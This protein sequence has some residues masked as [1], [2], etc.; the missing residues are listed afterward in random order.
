M[1]NNRNSGFLLMRLDCT[2]CLNTCF[3]AA[4]FV[5]VVHLMIGSDVGRIG[6]SS[7]RSL[8]WHRH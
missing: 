2:L 5:A 8:D 3:V 6:D 7:Q 4:E 1:Q